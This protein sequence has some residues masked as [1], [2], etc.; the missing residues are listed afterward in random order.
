MIVPAYNEASNLEVLLRAIE[1]QQS[2]PETEITI[3]D[4][5]STD[6]TVQVAQAHGAR[7]IQLERR[8]GLGNPAAARNLGAAHSGGDPLVFL[9][10]DCVPA[11]HWLHSL[12][13]AHDSGH[14][15]VGGA[16]DLPEG[17]GLTAR[18]DY[19]CG[20]YHVHSR[21]SA[22]AVPNHPPGNLSV[23]R[24]S[25]FSTSGFTA[26]GPAAYAHE[27][28]DWQAE[29]SRAGTSIYFEPRA[30]VLHHSRPGLGNLLRRSYRWGYSSLESKATSG[31]ARLS[32]IY[33]HPW[34]LILARPLLALAET[35]YIVGCWLRAGALEPLVMFPLVLLARLAYSFGVVVGGFRWLRR[36]R[37][38][39]PGVRPRWE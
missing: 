30:I 13:A 34:A 14:T 28:L 8:Q 15:V 26:D 6:E 7:V 18:L 12:L 21:R 5:G 22:G 1:R 2:A 33:R 38:A 25:F 20:W 10:A 4:N 3:V 32:W 29:L 9:D 23:R 17:L 27:E 37:F 16:L 24:E 36:R 31:M 35:V 19:Y 39:T 11:P